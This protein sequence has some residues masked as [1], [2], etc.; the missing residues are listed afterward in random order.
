M[1]VLRSDD[2]DY[3]GIEGDLGESASI[4]QTGKFTVIRVS[5]TWRGEDQQANIWISDPAVLTDLAVVL[6]AEAERLKGLTP[7]G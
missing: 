2:N 3:I 6:M 5:K 7:A 1:K 4:T